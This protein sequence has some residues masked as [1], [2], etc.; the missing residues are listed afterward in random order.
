MDWL[1]ARVVTSHILKLW[2]ACSTFKTSCW[3]SERPPLSLFSWFNDQTPTTLGASER[4]DGID[5]N[6]ARRATACMEFLQLSLEGAE[7]L[8]GP[9][10]PDMSLLAWMSQRAASV[11]R[12]S[13][14]PQ[15]MGA[16]THPGKRG[17]GISAATELRE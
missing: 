13:V 10:R 14:P 15:R 9:K 6:R 1:A 12:L 17:D 16:I 2:S 8:K 11:N 3:G 7:A 4:A 5:K